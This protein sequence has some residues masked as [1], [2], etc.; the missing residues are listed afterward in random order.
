V[1]RFERIMVCGYR[2]VTYGLLW[3]LE[4]APMVRETDTRPEG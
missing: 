4:F 3:R 2:E 1:K